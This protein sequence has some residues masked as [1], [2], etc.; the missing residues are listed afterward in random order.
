MNIFWG[1]KI[2]W[3]L[4]WGHYKIGLNLEVISMH[5]RVFSQGQGTEWGVLFRLLNFQIFFGYFKFLISLVG[6]V[7]R[8]ILD[9]SLRMKKK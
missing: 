1:M 2:F 8:S 9:P 3:I 7:E 6:G 5:F 4:F